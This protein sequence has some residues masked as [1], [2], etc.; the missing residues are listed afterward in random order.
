MA[1]AETPDADRGE[2]GK[3]NAPL[4][5]PEV[6]D[7]AAS[8]DGQRIA[9]T[10][11]TGF[12]GTCLVERLLRSTPGTRL[13]L[14]I[15]PGRRGVQNRLEREILR[16]DAFDRLRD[17]MGKDEFAAMAAERI[18]PIAADIT[19]DSIIHSMSQSTPTCADRSI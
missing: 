12:L 17:D 15:R 4:S 2:P 18:L 1:G 5:S 14:L 11:T 7:I 8:L 3:D 16:N 9:I 19:K 10:G 6:S 13:V